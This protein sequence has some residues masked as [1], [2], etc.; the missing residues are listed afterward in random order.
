M[1]EVVPEASDRLKIASDSLKIGQDVLRRN[2]VTN[3]SE[4]FAF[5][6]TKF[7]FHANF[8]R[9]FHFNYFRT[10]LEARRRISNSKLEFQFRSNFQVY[11]LSITTKVTQR[12]TAEVHFVRF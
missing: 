6:I 12:C 4:I 5:S 8:V 3:F 10:L 11:L 2:P 1:P 7:Q 9:I